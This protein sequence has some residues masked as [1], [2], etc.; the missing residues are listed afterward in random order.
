MR[1]SSPIPTIGTVVIMTCAI[2]KVPKVEESDQKQK[3]VTR[4][5][6]EAGGLCCC[7]RGG[8]SEQACRSNRGALERVCG[9]LDGIHSRGDRLRH[10][11]FRAF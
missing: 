2:Q 10:F 6:E 3:I 11:S 5:R 7:L 8:Y 9:P 4:R 1:F